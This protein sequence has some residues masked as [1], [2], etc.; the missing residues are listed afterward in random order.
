MSKVIVRIVAIVVD[1]QHLTMYKEDGDTIIIRQGD[2]RVRKIVDEV[3]PIIAKQGYAD[4]DLSSEYSN[5]YQR[6]EEKSNGSVRLFRVAKNKLKSLF[7]MDNDE[8]PVEV[9]SIGVV[10]HKDFDQAKGENLHNAVNE[11]IENAVSVSDP[12][13][14]EE[15]VSQQ[16]KITD[17]E[18]RGS[19]EESN[20]SD[21]VV[22]LVNGKIIP[23]ME[24]IKSQF[25][26]ATKL[27]STKGV[28]NFLLRLS[29]VID[30]RKH[31]VDD[32]LNFMERGDLPIADDGSI[33]VYKVLRTTSEKD[34]FVDCHSKKVK[35]WVG[36]YVCMD[37]SMVDHDR[38]KACS[39]GLHIARRGYLSGGFTGDVCV[40]AKLAPE[41][42]IAV[43]EYDADKLRACGYHI[44]G[45]LSDEHHQLIKNHKPISETTKGKIIIGKAIAGEHIG[46]THE[47]RITKQQGEGVIVTELIKDAK[48]VKTTKAKPVDALSDVD[49]ETND[50]VVDP[51]KVAKD[52]NDLT[53]KE[54]V[55]RLVEQINTMF[56]REQWE[57]VKALWVVLQSTKRKS[58][59]SWEKLG[60]SS[61][62]LKSMD[63]VVKHSNS[64]KEIPK[65]IPNKPINKTKREIIHEMIPPTTK[66][67][68]LDIISIKKKAKKSWSS[69]GVTEEQVK[70]I[71]SMSQK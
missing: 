2:H 58:K 45:L 11:I 27:G 38:R 69:L 53:R 67:Q 42:V 4:I 39:N 29:S 17:K 22:A 63:S 16:G 37:P 34:V 55:N 46:K 65:A 51:K 15:S 3:T 36:A 19:T 56:K 28:E 61:A 9:A 35:Q 18:K 64:V 62:F 57:E 44:I 43:P 41:D 1:K 71:E 48:P 5:P 14:N 52:F 26:R 8:K 59:V 49:E 20:Y 6:F 25:A 68:A 31:S 47:V 50:E 23:G 13:F 32:L 30:E 54:Q 21:T 10:P 24:K 70:H 33:L 12:S 60:V 66:Q 7:G 40:L